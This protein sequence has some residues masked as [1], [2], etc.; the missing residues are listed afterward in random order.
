MRKWIDY[1]AILALAF[2]GVMGSAVVNQAVPI[3]DAITFTLFGVG[4]IS[5]IILVKTDYPLDIGKQPTFLRNRSGRQE[6]RGSKNEVF[7]LQHSRPRW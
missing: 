7:H 4:M 5:S 6:E 3:P 2:V 1:M